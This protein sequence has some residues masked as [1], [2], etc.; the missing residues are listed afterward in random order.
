MLCP[1]SPDPAH[2][3][4]SRQMLQPRINNSHFLFNQGH[5]P[6]CKF[7]ISPSPF[8][9]R[10]DEQ[11]SSWDIWVFSGFCWEDGEWF[12][13]FG[14]VWSLLVHWFPILIPAGT[15]GN[16]NPSLTCSPWEPHLV[17]LQRGGKML[18]GWSKEQERKRAQGWLFF[19]FFPGVVH[20]ALAKMPLPHWLTSIFR[21]YKMQFT[22]PADLCSP[23]RP[24]PVLLSWSD[25][26]Q[27]LINN[28][29]YQVTRE[30]TSSA[31]L[32]LSV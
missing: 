32:F 19:F 6:G 21:P 15:W 23:A 16:K 27:E 26:L 18:Q 3:A 7:N 14:R 30:N 28:P 25:N 29:K 8:K 1:S 11:G 24:P 17:L 9:Q 20:S 10:K 13:S 2:G 4:G 22:H 12:Y 31:L 5:T